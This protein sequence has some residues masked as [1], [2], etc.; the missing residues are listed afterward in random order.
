MWR[1]SQAVGVDAQ[2]IRTLVP[3]T[4]VFIKFRGYIQYRQGPRERII[5]E[6]SGLNTEELVQQTLVG[7]EYHQ[8]MA[9]LGGEAFTNKRSLKH[10]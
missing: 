5:K 7:Q 3:C 1:H 6:S 9:Q 8:I 4:R 2:M 10:P